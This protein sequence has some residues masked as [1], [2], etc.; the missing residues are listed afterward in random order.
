MGELNKYS[1]SKQIYKH[2]YL[3]YLADNKRMKELNTAIL[4]GIDDAITVKA[5]LNG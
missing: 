4:R 5:K 1:N 3:F 2:T